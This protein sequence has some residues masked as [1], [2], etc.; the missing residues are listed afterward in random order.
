MT[1]RTNTVINLVG[2]IVPIAVMLVTVPVFIGSLGEARFGVL[3]I[4]WLL[5]G[6]LMFFDFGIGQAIS[7]ELARLNEADHEMRRRIFWTGLL[8]AL[9]FSCL[10]IPVMYVLAELL[11]ANVIDMPASVRTEILSVLPWIAVSLV[12]TILNAFFDGVLVGRKRFLLLNLKNSLSLILVNLAQVYVAL[13]ISPSLGM[14]VPAAVLG[15]A[16][17]TVPACIMAFRSVSA[18][19]RPRLVGGPMI[20]QML[21]YGGWVSVGSIAR[22]VVA[23]TDRIVIGWLSGASAVAIYAVVLNL[24]RRINFIPAALT[25]A[26]FPVI[27]ER[28]GAM[29]DDLLHKAIRINTALSLFVAGAVTL[30]IKPFLWIWIRPEFAEQAALLGHVLALSAFFGSNIAFAIVALRAMGDSKSST[31]VLVTQIVPF[32]VALYFGAI[33]YG[34]LGVAAVRIARQ[35]VD[36]RRMFARLN[37]NRYATRM[38]VPAIVF[39]LA[40]TGVEFIPGGPWDLASIAAR[41]ILFLVVCLWCLRLA[42]E[43]VALVPARLR[44][45]ERLLAK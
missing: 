16:V 34:V 21:G 45:W 28:Q 19:L 42:P 40:C 44:V 10:G 4:V 17:S 43:A 36:S 5:T 26:L 25:D 41:S 2:K 29:R 32:C 22:E 3:S 35:F 13:S 14:V 9:A 11:F 38:H 39:L 30:T 7:F 15:T 6:Y 12:P 33:W 24:T 31:V 23:N 37:M 1:I 27:A 8:M 18:G 20:R